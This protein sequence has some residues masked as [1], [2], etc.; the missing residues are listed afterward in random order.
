[1]YVMRCL[2]KNAWKIT[3]RGCAPVKQSRIHVVWWT[4]HRSLRS[5][6]DR[7][8]TRTLSYFARCVEKKHRR[9]Q[10]KKA[11]QGIIEAGLNAR[12]EIIIPDYTRTCQL[13][14]CSAFSR[15]TIMSTHQP[16]PGPSTQ[17]LPA[18]QKQ[19]QHTVGIGI[20]AGAEDAKYQ[21]KYK[22]L[23]RKVKEIETVSPNFLP[24]RHNF[25]PRPKENDKLHYRVL[26]AKRSIQRMKLERA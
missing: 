21:A 3:T 6:T 2:R 9:R 18:R 12:P 16:S 23:K 14:N 4:L 20:A 8:S 7:S 25:S 26:Q 22:D 10:P 13:S 15:P 1:M 17:P 19:K 11:R 24:S 5:L